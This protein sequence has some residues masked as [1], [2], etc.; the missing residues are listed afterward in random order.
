[1]VNGKTALKNKPKIVFY[2]LGTLTLAVAISLGVLLLSK[3]K[4][5]VPQTAVHTENSEPETSLPKPS[6]EYKTLVGNELD[7]VST[8][9]SQIKDANSWLTIELPNVDFTVEL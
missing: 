4:V 2:L 3:I 5:S 9:S 8:L 7:K 1:M 6:E